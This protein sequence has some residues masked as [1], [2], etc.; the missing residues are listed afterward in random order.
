[1]NSNPVR[2][3]N[4]FIL[5]R[6]SR[7]DGRVSETMETR[8]ICW[9]GWLADLVWR[10]L[11]INHPKKHLSQQISVFNRLLAPEPGPDVV[12][13][14]VTLSGVSSQPPSLHCLNYQHETIGKSY[15]SKKICYCRTLICGLLLATQSL[16][17]PLIGLYPPLLAPPVSCSGP[18]ECQLDVSAK[19]RAP[20]S[21]AQQGQYS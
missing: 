5:F 4:W 3:R 14:H 7:T 9:P 6:S 10:C 15:K 8:D 2:S 1:M 19:Y 17:H 16:D 13:R 20:G 21:G 18:C 12:I 11:I